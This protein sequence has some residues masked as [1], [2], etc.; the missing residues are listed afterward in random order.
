MLFVKINPQ[1]LNQSYMH[2]KY[3]FYY[4]NNRLIFFYYSALST[5]RLKKKSGKKNVVGR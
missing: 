4:Q 1:K 2:F 5:K 3:R